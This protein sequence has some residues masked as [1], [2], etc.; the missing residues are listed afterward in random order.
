MKADREDEEPQHE[1]ESSESDE[2]EEELENKKV[3]LFDE[4]KFYLRV[5]SAQN[6]HVL[7]QNRNEYENGSIREFQHQGRSLY[8]LKWVR[9]NIVSHPEYHLTVVCSNRSDNLSL[10]VAHF[11]MP[12]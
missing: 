3:S 9:S 12:S 5:A 6:C 11:R 4:S 8:F 2:E 7:A 10:H 1:D